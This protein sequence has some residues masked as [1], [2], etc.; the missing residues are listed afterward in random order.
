[1]VIIAF[2]CDPIGTEETKV[3]VT[4]YIYADSMQGD[5]LEGAMVMIEMHPDSFN[6]SS[7]DVMT[8]ANGRFMME[9]QVYPDLPAEGGT[10]GYSM[11]ALIFFGLSARYGSWTYIYRPFE[12]PFIV[13]IGD[14]LFVWPIVYGGA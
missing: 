3:W 4:G 7:S 10:T 6:V 1:M 9:I 8:D 5:G 13:G 2:S 12:D 11:P 14:T